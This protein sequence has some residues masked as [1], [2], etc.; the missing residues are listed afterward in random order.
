VHAGHLA[1]E[2]RADEYAALVID[3]WNG[4]FERA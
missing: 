4:G 3:W 1:Y 2:D